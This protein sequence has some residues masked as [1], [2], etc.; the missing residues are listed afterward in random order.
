MMTPTHHRNQADFASARLCG[1]ARRDAA[2]HG[3]TGLRPCPVPP[4]ARDDRPGSKV[5][6]LPTVASGCSSIGRLQRAAGCAD[7]QVR[8]GRS[9]RAGGHRSPD[10]PGGRWIRAGECRGPRAC[11]VAD[12]ALGT[13]TRS[14][15]RPPL[16]VPGRA[17][18]SAAADISRLPSGPRRGIM[19]PCRRTPGSTNSRRR[20]RSSRC[21][22]G[23]RR[24]AAA[25]WRATS[26]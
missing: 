13:P 11:D 9:A 4:S 3:S 26:S 6:R 5:R 19:R 12:L 16:R 10:S 25:G 1:Q 7:T 22:T 18:R 20:W 21:R 14:S 17:G 23:K 24:A 2:V 15:R 8:D